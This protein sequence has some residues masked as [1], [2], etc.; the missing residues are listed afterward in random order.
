MCRSISGISIL[1]LMQFFPNYRITLTC[2]LAHGGRARVTFAR[3]RATDLTVGFTPKVSSNVTPVHHY[4]DDDADFFF[5]ACEVLGNDANENKDP[6]PQMSSRFPSMSF[7]RRAAQIGKFSLIV[8]KY[9]ATH[10]LTGVLQPI[11][12][13]RKNSVYIPK[14]QLQGCLMLLIFM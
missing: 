14:R 1:V 11:S 4:D 6:S 2:H 7:T 9:I 5:D 3:D 10:D 13:I 12:S 8:L